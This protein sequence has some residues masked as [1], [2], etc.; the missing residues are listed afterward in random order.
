MRLL[1]EIVPKHI[2]KWSEKRIKELYRQSIAELVRS[3][4]A[5]NIDSML[6]GKIVYDEKTIRD[7]RIYSY[8]VGQVAAI[9]G[10]MDRLFIE[11]DDEGKVP[12]IYI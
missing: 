1:K 8:A 10:I 12:E 7:L 9:E 5:V 3:R 6:N 11:Y 4:K 2:S